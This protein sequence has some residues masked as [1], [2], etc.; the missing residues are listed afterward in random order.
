LKS[1]IGNICQTYRKKELFHF[2]ENKAAHLLYFIVKNQ[3]FT[4][5]NKHIA[6]FLFYGFLKE[7]DYYIQMTDL[8][9]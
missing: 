9:K 7:M 2:A 3:S 4:D 8:K 1:S 6:A 5:G